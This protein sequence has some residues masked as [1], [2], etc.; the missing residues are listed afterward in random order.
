[1]PLPVRGAIFVVDFVGAAQAI[2]DARHQVQRAKA[3][4]KARVFRTLIGIKAQ[5]KL[6]DT[7]QPLKLGRVDQ[8]DHQLAIF[9][10]GAETDYVVNRI[11]IYSFS[12]TLPFGRPT[13][14]RKVYHS[15]KSVSRCA[16]LTLWKFS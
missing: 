1:M 13:C 7:P 2:E 11:A 5:A 4:S 8:T 3:V 12:Q 15:H 14:F 6:L 10:V 16:G 9:R